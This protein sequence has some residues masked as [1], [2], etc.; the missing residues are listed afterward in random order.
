MYRFDNDYNC[1]AHP[2]V[3]RALQ[4][5]NEE[6]YDGYGMDPWCEKASEEI[7]RHL[8][9]PQ[10]AV[11]FLE[12]GTQANR[13]VIAAALRPWQSV[14][15]ADTGHIHV[16]E[17]GA[18]E[19]AGHK[20]EVIPSED[21]ILTAEQVQERVAAYRESE[22]QEHI[23]QPKMLYI[24]HPTEM[25]A[26][27]SRA[28]LE[29]LHQ[30]CRKYGM[31]LFLDG[32]RLSYGLESENSDM[33]LKDIARLTDCFTIGGTKCG[34]L[35]GEA[36]VLCNPQLQCGFRSAMKQNGA[37]MAKGW[38]LGLQ[39]Y[40]LFR[41]GIYFEIARQ[42]NEYA[43]RIRRAFEDEGIE[44]AMDTHTNQLFVVLERRQLEYLEKNYIFQHWQQVDED[45]IMIRICTSWSTTREQVDALVSNIE[46]L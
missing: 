41:D 2:L 29:Q 26:I 1:G 24:S 25:G 31:Y 5:Y 14:L 7:R 30:V 12:G 35:V 42:A 33:T 17:T 13:T 39:F 40:T 34:T 46:R 43:Q 23:T 11:H 22:I 45:H 27:Y 20:I 19:N 6:G 3:L 16:H 15:C 37:M 9:T 10:A 28:Q 21:G 44:P 18:V 36:V 38:L 32:A 8:G 4:E